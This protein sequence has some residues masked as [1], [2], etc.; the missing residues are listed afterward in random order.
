MYLSVFLE[1]FRDATW[2]GVIFL[3]L[4][5]YIEAIFLKIIRK[6]IATC[7]PGILLNIWS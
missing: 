1:P 3:F 6:C 4:V 2:I 7:N 5:F